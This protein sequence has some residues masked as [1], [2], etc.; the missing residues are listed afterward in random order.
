M[1]PPCRYSSSVGGLYH[2]P[3]EESSRNTLT[4]VIYKHYRRRRKAGPLPTQTTPYEE[5]L[6]HSERALYVCWCIGESPRGLALSTVKQSQLQPTTARGSVERPS[7][8]TCVQRGR[9]RNKSCEPSPCSAFLRAEALPRG[10]MLG[11][12]IRRLCSSAVHPNYGTSRPA[13]VRRWC[14]GC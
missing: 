13:L 4:V 10:R 14:R 5:Q 2:S 12:S 3:A 6:K 7:S 8:T 9:R 11:L 1:C